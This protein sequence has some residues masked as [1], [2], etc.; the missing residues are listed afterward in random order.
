MQNPLLNLNADLKQLYDQGL[1]VDIKSGYLFVYRVPYVTVEKVVKL[2]SLVSSLTL[3]GDITQRPDNHVAFFCGEKPCHSDGTPISEIINATQDQALTDK[4]TINHTFSSKP[5]SG[6]YE[7][8]YDKMMSYINILSGPA[9]AID[10]TVTAKCFGIRETDALESVFCYEDTNSARANIHPVNRLIEGLKIGIIGL[11]GTG[12]YVLDLV[13]KTPVGEIHLFDADPQFLHNSF[14]S[15]GAPKI[16]QLRTRPL[17]VQYFQELY[18]KMHKHIFAHAVYVGSD[19]LLE[20]ASMDYIF[21]CIDNSKAKQIIIQYLLDKGIPFVDSGMGI[22][23][24]DDSLIGIIRVT[25]ASSVK[26]DHLSE[27]ISYDDGD[28]D[29]YST[30]IQVAELNAFNACLAV[31]QWKKQFKVYQD[32]IREFHTTY[33]I[34]TGQLINEDHSA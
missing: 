30:N 27:R 2:G 24:V 6:F 34:N 29:D 12:S 26:S 33:T 4:L 11:G 32:L 23:R 22:E 3:A 9:Q 28:P 19:N 25:G 15:P 10:P 20:L 1:Y 14:R 18:A 5:E 8:Y 17:K 21:I 13:A 31:M 16:D 7:N